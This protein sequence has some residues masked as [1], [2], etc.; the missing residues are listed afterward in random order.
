MKRVF[1][2]IIAWCII[3]SFAGC[4]TIFGRKKQKIKVTSVTENAEIYIGETN[5]MNDTIKEVFQKDTKYAISARKE[6]YKTRHGVISAEKTTFLLS[7]FG[8]RLLG[9]WSFWLDG[10]RDGGSAEN[11]EV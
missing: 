4:V 3:F 7:R 10:R 9:S 6:G 11:D 2:S 8:A 1:S 5:K